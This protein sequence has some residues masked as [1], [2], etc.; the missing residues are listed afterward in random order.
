MLVYTQHCRSLFSRSYPSISPIYPAMGWFV[1]EL[2]RSKIWMQHPLSMNI[3]QSSINYPSNNAL[4]FSAF[5]LGKVNIQWVKLLKASDTIRLWISTFDQ[6]TEIETDSEWAGLDKIYNSFGNSIN[7]ANWD[8]PEF[9]RI[10]SI[11]AC[12]LLKVWF[13]VMGS[14]WSAAFYL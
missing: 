14:I 13:A 11:C 9:W 12:G 4:I 5:P 2:L 3:C 10:M 7:L 6:K 1:G 8:W